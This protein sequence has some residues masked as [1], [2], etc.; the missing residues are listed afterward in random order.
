MAVAELPTAKAGLKFGS[1]SPE[2]FRGCKSKASV[3]QLTE[4]SVLGK[5]LTAAQAVVS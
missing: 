2:S 5:G 3:G 4:A 1:S